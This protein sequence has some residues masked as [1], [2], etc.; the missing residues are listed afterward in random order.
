MNKKKIYEVGGS[1]RDSFLDLVSKDK[2][3]VVIANS[4]EEMKSD[5]LS[6]GA[7]IFLE[8]PE[9]F[10]IRCK[11]EPFGCCDFVLGRKDG[12]YSDGRR[13]DSVTLATT[14]EEEVQRRD[15]TVNGLV[16]DTETGIIH[17][18]VNGI[19][20]IKTKTLRCIGNP[21]DRFTE[22]SLRLIRAMR[23]CIT[24]DFKLSEDIKDCLNNDNLV[25]GLSNISNERIREELYKCFAYSTVW[26][27]NFLDNFKY[28]RFQLFDG[29]I[30]LKPTLESK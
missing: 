26:T 21:V 19:A 4:Y 25:D 15:F 5:L 13:P 18:Y 11:L 12:F 24:K 23:F 16:R 14:I 20:D 1:V 10:A 29:P 27:L 8:R 6:R 2:D 7:Q 30:W 17:D 9:Y 28:L 22:D 3:F